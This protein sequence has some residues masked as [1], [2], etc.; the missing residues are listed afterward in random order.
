MDGV[1]AVFQVALL[2]EQLHD[3]LGG[4]TGNDDH[5][6]HHGQHH[7]AHEDHHDITE[8]T[9]ELPGGQLTAHHQIGAQPGHGE[10]T[11]IDADLHQGHIEGHDL[12]GLGEVHVD[13]VGHLAELLLLVVLPDEGLYHADT[14]QVLLHH[15]VQPVVLLKHPLEEGVGRL[16]DDQQAHR[17]NGNDNEEDHCQLGVDGKGEH[18]CANQHDGTAHRDPNDH[19]K[20]HLHVGHIGGQTGN[21]TAGGELVNVGKGKLLDAVVHLPAQVA[22]EAGGRPGGK[23]AR[24]SAQQQG[25][26]GHGNYRDAILQDMG[27][28]ARL[29]ALI[30]Q[31][32]GHQRDQH[33]EGHLADDKDGG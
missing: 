29:D 28:A 18:P 9:G 1:G 11:G 25:D 7:Q 10:H 12:L 15:V 22:G 14:Q 2:V 30:Q 32:A 33:I 31:L 23:P 8:H 6:Q 13:L 3:T 4:G 27:H 26:E 24:Q 21:D 5:N 16:H 20:G 19:H 17:Q